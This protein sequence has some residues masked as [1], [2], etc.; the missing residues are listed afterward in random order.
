MRSRPVARLLPIS[1][2]SRCSCTS[3]FSRGSALRDSEQP[4]GAALDEI[5]DQ[6]HRADAE[7]IPELRIVALILARG[8]A[9]SRSS[10]TRSGA[11]RDCSQGNASKFWPLQLFRIA[12]GE[13]AARDL[14]LARTVQTSA[15]KL[16][17]EGRIG[18]RRIAQQFEIGADDV[19][20]PLPAVID[21]EIDGDLGADHVE[22]DSGSDA[23]LRPDSAETICPT[24]SGRAGGD[25]GEL[26][27][28][29][30]TVRR[31]GVAVIDQQFATRIRAE[32]RM[33]HTVPSPHATPATWILAQVVRN[34][35]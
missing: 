25:R 9:V 8:L 13:H 32:N 15:S 17:V 14:N 10:D 19:A 28:C 2:M 30:L 34:T 23:A 27:P 24:R 7:M 1:F 26:L 12:G 35:S 16:N 20:T 18:A 22:A 5:A 4:G 33:R 21:L 29:A 6:Q 31:R 3:Q 11:S